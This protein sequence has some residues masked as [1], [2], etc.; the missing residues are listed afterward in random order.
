[1]TGAREEAAAM[2]WQHGKPPHRELVEVLH[3]GRV[4]RVRAIWGCDG[5]LP[6]WES[7]DEDTLWHHSAFHEWRYPMP[8]ERSHPR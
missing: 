8:E 6:H 4:I 1:M 2:T 3:N 7:E 5:T